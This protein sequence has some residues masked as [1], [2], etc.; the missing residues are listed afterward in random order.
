MIKLCS[1]HVQLKRTF[2]GMWIASH[3]ELLNWMQHDYWDKG[4]ALR[5]EMPDPLLDYPERTT[6]ER[7]F[8]VWCIHFMRNPKQCHFHP[9]CAESL[10]LL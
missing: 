8:V 10:H 2:I 4:K 6:G 1:S 7:C 5:A 9:A 3:T